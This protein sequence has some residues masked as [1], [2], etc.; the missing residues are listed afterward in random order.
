MKLFPTL[1]ALIAL[2]APATLTAAPFCDALADVEQLPKKYAKRGPFHADAASGWVVG[3]D[4]LKASFTVTEETTALWS[5]LREAFATRGAQLVV[6]AAPPRPLFAP[7]GV[8]PANRDLDALQAGFSAYIEALNAAGIPAPDLTQA[9]SVDVAEDYYF[10]RDTHWTP[11]GAAWSSV[12]L[13]TLMGQMPPSLEDLPFAETYSE[14]GS[15]SAVVEK[16]CGTR[17][18]AEETVAPIYASVGGAAALLGDAGDPTVALVG[19]SFSDRYQTDAYQVAG[20][21]SWA[22]GA[23]VQN[24]SLTGGGLV[25]AMSGFI[26][27]GALEQGQFQTV[28]WETPYTNPLTQI[29]GLRQILGALEASE[30]QTEIYAGPLNGDWQAIALGAE[31]SEDG[32]LVIETPGITAGTLIVELW[33]ADK[34]K[35]RLKLRKSDRL[36]ADLRSDVWHVS[37]A[38]LPIAD[39]AR[40]KIKLDG[41]ANAAR[42]MLTN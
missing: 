5:A 8:V 30:N 15:L 39:V 7:E 13:A 24:V 17:P 18:V 19:T 9:L 4:Q 41:D 37:L 38:A 11:K 22:L 35:L 2:T 21:L 32:S 27:S 40:V 14:K 20:A 34:T 23:D 33:S 29:A 10:A 36:E 16:V 31:V 26:Q 42:V 12:E 6:L 1:A 25:G 28:V 3:E